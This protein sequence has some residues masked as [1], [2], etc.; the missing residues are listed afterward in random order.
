MMTLRSSTPLYL[1]LS[2]SLAAVPGLAHADGFAL[3]EQSAGSLGMA[4][5]VSASITDPDAVWY[6]PAALPFMPGYQVSLTG[7][8]YLGQVNFTPITA[9]STVDAKP[10]RQFVPGF[11][12][13]GQLTDRVAVGLGVNIPFGL[14]VQWPGDWLGRLNGIQSSMLMLDINPVVAYKILPNLSVAAGLDIIKGSIDIT[15]GLPT[16]PVDTVRIGASAWGLGANVAVLYRILPEQFHV[17]AS[18]RSRVKLGFSGRAHFEVTEPVFTSQLYDQGASTELTLPD[19][20]MFGVMYRP[21][22]SVRIGL[23][24]NVVLWSTYDKVT[25]KFDD[26][27]TPSAGLEPHY[28]DIVNLRLGVEWATPTQGLK[29]RAGFEYD[30][31]PAPASG[32]SPLL[33]D[34]TALDLCLG[35]GYHVPQFGADLGYMHVFHQPATAHKPTDPTIPPQ[36]PEGTYRTGADV[37]GLTLTGRF[38]TDHS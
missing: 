10:I 13:T 17:A 21:H 18:Y 26:P 6:D 5:A 9:G 2:A 1:W 15:N 38:E 4:S 3:S 14:G 23:D 31:S 25:V 19:L 33:P 22:P 36:S 11:F 32:L 28:H 12:A 24:A 30:P 35:I 16:S 8:A 29:L 7:A 27:A 20:I 34:A 37:I